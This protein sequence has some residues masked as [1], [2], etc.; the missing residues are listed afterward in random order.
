MAAQG[1]SANPAKIDL[2]PMPHST[3]IAVANSDKQPQVAARS[4]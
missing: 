4:G 3:R 2:K 1:Q